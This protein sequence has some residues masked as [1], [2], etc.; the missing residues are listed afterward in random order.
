MADLILLVVAEPGF[1]E[2]DLVAQRQAALALGDP[3]GT[4][5]GRQRG[6]DPRKE[7]P[8]EFLRSHVRLGQFRDLIDQH[9]DLLLGLLDQLG[10]EGLFAAAHAVI[11]RAGVCRPST[12]RH[13]ILAVG[14]PRSGA[15]GKAKGGP[16]LS[17]PGALLRPAP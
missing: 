3:D 4:A 8:V 15:W 10:V 1:L 11:N 6:D 5:D 13:S 2:V 9:A 7:L 12:S 16:S 14:C 17:R